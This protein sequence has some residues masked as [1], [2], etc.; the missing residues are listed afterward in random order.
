MKPSTR[1]LL[2]LFVS[3]LIVQIVLAA[4]GGGGGSGGGSGGSISGIKLTPS[5][6]S[7]E[8]SFAIG[9]TYKI[10]MSTANDY[11]FKISEIN[12]DQQDAD[13]KLTTTSDDLISQSTLAV[14]GEESFDLDGDGKND[15]K[16]RLIAVAKSIARFEFTDVT[17]TIQTTEAISQTSELKCG[18]LPTL[19]E[20]VECRIELSEYE[21]GKELELQY[22]PEECRTIINQG[23]QESCIQRYES[24]QQCWQNPVGPSRISCVKKQ[25]NLGDIK[26]EKAT[27]LASNPSN[28]ET[29][30]NE[31]EDKVFALVKFRVYDLEERAEELLEEGASEEAV[32][33]LVAK[34]EEKKLEFND[35]STIEDKKNVIKAVRNIWQDFVNEIKDQ[36]KKSCGDIGQNPTE[37]TFE[38]SYCQGDMCNVLNEEECEKIDIVLENL[39]S[40]EDGKQDCQWVENT[41][42]PNK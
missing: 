17:G 30:L 39:K 19:R 12:T 36:I 28:K 3:L 21:L 22:L 11:N 29:C 37:L 26:D 5:K 42:R 13:L 33:N 18:D 23:L 40:G 9:N 2:F 31:L 4:G 16:I 7:E 14:G 34:L 8:I 25:F 27:C 32:I 1:A 10:T 24:V 6:L 20:R 15:L 41:C 38:L 35:A